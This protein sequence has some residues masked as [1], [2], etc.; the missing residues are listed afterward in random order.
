MSGAFLVLVKGQ[1]SCASDLG[2]SVG[3]SMSGKNDYLYLLEVFDRFKAALKQSFPKGSGT[4]R[5]LNHGKS[6]LKKVLI[7]NFFTRLGGMPKV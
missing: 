5:S 1:K 2:P 3:L 4:A 6:I 7:F